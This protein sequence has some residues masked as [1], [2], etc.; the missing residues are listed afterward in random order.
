MVLKNY[1][2]NPAV[3]TKYPKDSM[4][5]FKDTYHLSLI[6]SYKPY[7]CIQTEDG[8][9]NKEI[10]YPVKITTIN[11]DAQIILMIILRQIRRLIQSND[12]KGGTNDVN[13]TVFI[14]SYKSLTKPCFTQ[15]GIDELRTLKR[16]LKLRNSP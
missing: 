1:R 16:L 9:V 5:R 7:Q 13:I 2:N 10:P 6:L 14:K 8:I 11:I 3:H 15:S 12:Q 4:Q